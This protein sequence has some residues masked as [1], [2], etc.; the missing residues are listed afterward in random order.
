MKGLRQSAVEYRFVKGW[1]RRAKYCRAGMW[2]G[3]LARL[4][5]VATNTVHLIS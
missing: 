5:Y 4:L 2:V 1:E 3:Y